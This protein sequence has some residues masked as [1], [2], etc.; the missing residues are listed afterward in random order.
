MIGKNFKLVE[1]QR[2]S[3][4]V[5]NTTNANV[6][7]RFDDQ[8]SA[9]GNSPCNSYSAPYQAGSGQALTFGPV[10]TTLRACVDTSLQNLET[11]YYDAL[12]SV[13]SYSFDGAT[14]QLTYD[15]GASILKFAA[16]GTSTGSVPGMPRTG[17]AG[18]QF[19]VA[20]LLVLVAVGSV[21]WGLSVR[22]TSKVEQS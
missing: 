21:A 11:E 16:D 20:G 17:F 2:S 18:T 6:T 7:L 13:N 22:R 10:L 19:L 15:N 8:G 4:D 5:L 14:L 12:K 9:G 3:Q 1:L